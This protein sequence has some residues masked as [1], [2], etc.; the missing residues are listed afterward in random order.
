MQSE[1]SATFCSL[2]TKTWKWR[3]ISVTDP[4]YE[5]S[6]KSVRWML[7]CSVP[8]NQNDK[9][10]SPLS[11]QLCECAEKLISKTETCGVWRSW[12]D[13][14]GSDGAHCDAL[15]FYKRGQGNFLMSSSITFRS[16]LLLLSSRTPHFSK[17]NLKRTLPNR[18]QMTMQNSGPLCKQQDYF[19]S[20]SVVRQWSLNNWK[21]KRTFEYTRQFTHRGRRYC[22]IIANNAWRVEHNRKM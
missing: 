16:L 21:H 5:I 14:A 18:V 10:T 22:L 11:Q 17:S 13:S 8:K 20:C 15:S 7:R 1:V 12:L 4:T 2:S 3:Q 9:T 19:F 6:R